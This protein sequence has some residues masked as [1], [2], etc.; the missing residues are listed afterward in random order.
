MNEKTEEIDIEKIIKSIEEVDR[1][2]TIILR[3]VFYKYF[4]TWGIIF[5]LF[6]ILG[7]LFSP[8]SVNDYLK[9]FQFF[10]F[11]FLILIGGYLTSRY[12][13][14]F[15]RVRRFKQ[16]ALGIKFGKIAR[17]YGLAFYTILIIVLSILMIIDIINYGNLIWAYVLIY[18]YYLTLASIPFYVL[19][20][21]RISFGKILP[22][23][24]I[25]S[26]TFLIGLISPFIIYAMIKRTDSTFNI[27]VSI[28]WALVG[29]FWIVS[30]V[31]M[32]FRGDSN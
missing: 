23:G 4:V 6:S 10:A 20:I 19:I 30:G 9:P 22:Q 17:I 1:A 5:L 16:A 2:E 8:F 32:L 28:V 27:F 29:I 25:S 11:I 31:T 15:K 26:V 24:Y 7:I 12:A 3:G 14:T 13:R 21:I 18:I